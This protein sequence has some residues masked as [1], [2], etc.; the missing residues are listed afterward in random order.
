MA[1]S[2]EVG[3]LGRVLSKLSMKSIPTWDSNRN[4]KTIDSHLKAF[5]N[6]VGGLELDKEELARELISTLRGQALTLVENLDDDECKDYQVIKTMLLEV[7]HKEKP[8]HTLIQEFYGMKWKKKKQTI[9]QYATALNLTWKKIAKDQA[10]DN[11]TSEAILKNRLM[12]GISAADPKFGEWLQFTTAADIEF[13]K[14]A[15]EAENKYDVFKTTRERVYEHEWEDEPTFF[16]KEKSKS[17]KKEPDRSNENMKM[18]EIIQSQNNTFQDQRRESYDRTQNEHEYR[19]GPT[20]QYSGGDLRYQGQNRSN[21]GQQWSPPRWNPFNRGYNQYQNNQNNGQD[22]LQN[23]TPQHYY[24]NNNENGP[25]QVGYQT[26]FFQDQSQL[27]NYGEADMNYFYQR[28]TSERR[29]NQSKWNDKGY[30]HYQNEYRYHPYPRQRYPNESN[31]RG[32]YQD[33]NEYQYHPSPD[34][35]PNEWNS[36]LQ[37][38]S[39]WNTVDQ[40]TNDDYH[41]EPRLRQRRYHETSCEQT[42]EKKNEDQEDYWKYL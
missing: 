28:P 26:N 37:D 16:N 10:K 34:R 9:R 6:A 40:R 42:N 39:W 33:K 15:I 38:R 18:N 20:P 24:Q 30:N 22:A 11:K 2:Q 14:L 13:K 29:Q 23:E 36:G 32:Y 25:R 19:W 35:Y 1:Q 7:F 4:E 12:D 5:E 41:G 17:R 21:W 8:I 3:E 27:E 31:D